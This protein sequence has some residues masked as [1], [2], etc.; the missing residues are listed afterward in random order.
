MVKND[1]PAFLLWSLS[2]LYISDFGFKPRWP[3]A[4]LR[5]IIEVSVNW[6]IGV[7]IAVTNLSVSFLFIFKYV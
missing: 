6:I 7:I 2:S 5:V 1:T 3:K 4:L